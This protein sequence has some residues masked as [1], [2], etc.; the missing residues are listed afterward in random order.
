M[1]ISILC[2]YI[3]DYLNVFELISTEIEKIKTT[4]YSYIFVMNV[5][6]RMLKYEKFEQIQNKELGF[7]VIH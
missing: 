5:K 1:V 2:N 6:L 7:N 3:G 4:A